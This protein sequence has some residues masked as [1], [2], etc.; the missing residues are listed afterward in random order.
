M[1][2]RASWSV[3]A[4]RFR[5]TATPRDFRQKFNLRDRFAIYIGRID[6]NKGC[7]ELFDYF[8]RYSRMLAEGMHLVLIGN[9]IIPI[10]DAPEDPSPRLRQ[11]S[12]QVR[13]AGGG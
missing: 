8:Q 10:P 4:R 13:C 6:E 12:G 5:R 3:S 7:A 1:R 9:P 2:C 11:R